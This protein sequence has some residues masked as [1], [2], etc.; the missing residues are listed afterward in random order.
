MNARK[1]VALAMTTAVTAAGLALGTPTAQADITPTSLP[2]A[3]VATPGHATPSQ[4]TTHPN[5]AAAWKQLWGPTEITASYLNHH[6]KK[7]VS[8]SFDAHS[9]R[10]I[11]SF[12]CWNGGDHSKARLRIYNVETRK[13]IGDSGA[14]PCDWTYNYIQNVAGYKDGQ[15]LRFVL[16]SVGKAHTTYVTAYRAG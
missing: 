5:A 10:V 7:W 1:R 11:G 3:A 9:T 12:R 8:R 6:G 15:P 16:T 14:Q 4:G 13:W 2:G